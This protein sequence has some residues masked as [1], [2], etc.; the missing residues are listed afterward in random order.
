MIYNPFE[1]ITL[2]IVYIIIDTV[3]IAAI[4]SYYNK[5]E[6]DPVLKILI[7]IGSRNKPCEEKDV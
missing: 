6:A 4:K 2:K 5:F 7:E 1:N 3:S